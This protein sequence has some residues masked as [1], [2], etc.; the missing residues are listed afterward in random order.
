MHVC[1][2]RDCLC[3][4]E[5]EV[6]L[7]KGS[8]ESNAHE[9]VLSV[10][11]RDTWLNRFLGKLRGYNIYWEQ[12]FFMV[13]LTFHLMRNSYDIIYTQEYVH[14]VGIGRLKNWLAPNTKL[15]YCEGFIS[16]GGV[17]LKH[18]DVLQ[19]V[20][21]VNYDRLKNEA[22]RERKAHVPYTAFL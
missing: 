13:R 4:K 20:N 3:K 1:Y 14:M 21:K 18:A 7:V 15:I 10:P 16:P 11:K 9:I 2:S 5:A 17:R 19:E 8:G 6:F 12:V 22:E